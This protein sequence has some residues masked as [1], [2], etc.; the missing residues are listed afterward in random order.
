MDLRNKKVLVVGFG[1]SGQAVLHYLLEQGARIVVTDLQKEEALKKGM[2]PFH[3]H[4]IDWYLGGHDEEVF[5]AADLIV[6][7]PGV[8]WN[9]PP[10]KRVREGGIPIVSELELAFTDSRFQKSKPTVIAVTGTNGKTTTVSLLHH[11]FKTAGQKSLLAG[12]VGRP[13]IDAMEEI[14][15]VRFLVLEVS[16]YQLEATPSLK[17]NVAI[18]LNVTEDHLE[19][20]ESFADYVRAKAKLIRQTGVDGLVIYNGEDEAVTQSVEQ[21]PSHRLVFSSKRQ[22]KLGG[23]VEEGKLFCRIT[24]QDKPLSFSL[25]RVP[26]KGIHN[27]ENMLAALLALSPYIKDV[28]LLQKGLETFEPLPHRMQKVR[29]LNGITFINDSKGTNVG[30]AV[31]AFAATKAPILWIAGGR[32]KRGSFEPLK[33]WLKKKSK[34]SFLFG[35]AKERMFSN[36]KGCGEMERV[37]NLKEAVRKAFQ[38]ARPGDT[39]LF[40]PACSSFDMYRDYVERGEHF[41]KEV[42]AL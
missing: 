3:G 7:S 19:W 18:W 38:T 12:N 1:R 39:I 28:A 4:P 21:I 11:L 9:L 8:P 17:P 40:S 34:K 6:V 31:Q 10:L 32:D 23:W 37:A 36:L 16:S 27:W 20:H 42:K 22:V 14:Q 15:K 13:L 24:L 2:E 26:L 5:L 29:E 25:Q 35:E 41:I 30:A 33:E